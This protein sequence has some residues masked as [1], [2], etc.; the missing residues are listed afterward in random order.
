MV[1]V[2]VVIVGGGHAGVEAA[3]AAARR[4]A[5]VA[6]VTQRR[7]TVGVMSCNPSIGGVGKGHIVREIDTLDGIMGVAA[8]HA[9]IHHRMLNGSKGAAVQGP[10]VQADRYQYQCAVHALLGHYA[11]L[12]IVEAEVADLTVA[13]S[14]VAGVVC[15]DGRTI[16][17]AA[18]VI[19]SGT[20]LNATLFRGQERWEGGRFQDDAANRLGDRLR[21]LRSAQGRLK[22]GTPPRLD[23]RTIDWAKLAPQPSDSRSWT[24][25]TTTTDRILPQVA[26]AITRTTLATHDIIRQGLERSPS[27]TGAIEGQG[28]RYCPS[29]EDK[30]VRFGDREGHQIFLEPEGLDD[31][32]VYPNGISTSLPSDVQAS[33]VA[34]I[35][36]LEEATIV[37]PGYAVEYDFLDPRGLKVTLES[38]ELSGLFCAGQINGT[39]GY[40][41]A[42]G[43]GLI[44]GANAAAIALSLPTIVLDRAVS[45]IGVMIDDLTLQGVSEPYRMLTA[46]AEHRLV[47]RADNAEQRLGAIS[48]AFGLLSPDRQRHMGARESRRNHIRV[49]LANMTIEQGGQDSCSMTLAEWVTRGADDQHLFVASPELDQDLLCEVASD[50]RYAPYVERQRREVERMRTDDA[51]PLPHDLAYG[52]VPGLSIEMIERLQASGPE[53]LGQARRIRGMTPAALTAL[54][55]HTRRRAV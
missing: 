23:G 25:S 8:D 54:L 48:A 39:T 20:F 35:P 33:L 2:D 49:V 40:E 38:R 47:L 19:A 12:T 29:I 32:L 27:M 44:A 9:A 24:M 34:S 7:S 53:T 10:R 16:A 37:V 50:L 15:T 3:A 14:Q 13:C 26:C 30:V 31:H 36:G 11:T 22:T 41:E 55:L 43:Q 42:A 45:Y 52:E 51:L 1:E 28:P 17:A 46:R 18:V 4:G 21:E 5:R 6:L